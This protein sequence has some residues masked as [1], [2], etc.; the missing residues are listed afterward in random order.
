MLS[1]AGSLNGKFHGNRFFWG[2]AFSLQLWTAITRTARWR[3]ASFEAFLR[4]E[5][6]SSSLEGLGFEGLGF[7]DYKDLGLRGLE[8]QGLYA[9]RIVA[10]LQVPLHS[11][12]LF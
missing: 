5:T 11:M 9:F 12:K 7:R 3:T 1:S 10:E 8:V 6:R 4:T 2:G